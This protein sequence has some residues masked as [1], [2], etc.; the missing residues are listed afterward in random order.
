MARV[1]VLVAGDR[2]AADV[3][4]RDHRL[5]GPGHPVGPAVGAVVKSVGW[6][7]GV[8]VKVLVVAE[9]EARDVAVRV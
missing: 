4:D 5:G 3:L 2:V 6:P 9:G 7:P 1:M 8:M